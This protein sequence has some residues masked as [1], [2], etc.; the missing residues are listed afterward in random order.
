[1]EK[2]FEVSYNEIEDIL[3]L[4][5]KEIVKFSI[6][7]SLPSGDIVVDIDNSGKISGLE[8]FNATEFFSKLNKT[9]R[10]VK[11]AQVRMIYSPSYTSININLITKEDVVKSN[12]IIPYSK[13]MV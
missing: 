1:M 9:L 12:L 13:N 7:L 3:Y 8:I 2:N 6:D 11:N 4:G 5:S 10:S